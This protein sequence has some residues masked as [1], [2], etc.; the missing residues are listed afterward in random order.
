M[1]NL[2]RH[3]YIIYLFDNSHST[4]GTWEHIVGFTNAGYCHQLQQKHCRQ[5]LETFPCPIPTKTLSYGSCYYYHL[6][7][8]SGHML[9]L[10]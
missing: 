7:L 6:S 9:S 4:V 10:Q 2:V 5:R 3:T 8:L 1:G